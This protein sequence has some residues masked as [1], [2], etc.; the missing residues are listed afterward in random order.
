MQDRSSGVGGAF[1][2][3][4]G[5]GGQ[6]QKRRG[7][8]KILFNVTIVTIIIFA[9]LSI[10]NLVRHQEEGVETNVQAPTIEVETRNIEATTEDGQ[11]VEVTPEE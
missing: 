7:A 2:G 8:E 9:S 1:G 3:G 11:P 10:W 5:G 6:F 4:D